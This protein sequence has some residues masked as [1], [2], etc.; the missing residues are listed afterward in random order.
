MKQLYKSIV[1]KLS[2]IDTIKHIDID[3]G[4]LDMPQKSNP[5]QYPALLVGLN[6]T[7][8]NRTTK[9]DRQ[10]A[11]VQI[12]IKCVNDYYL[13][14]AEYSSQKDKAHDKI[15]DL[16]ELVYLKLQNQ[17]GEGYSPL[18]R[19]SSSSV[20]LGEGTVVREV[21]FFCKYEDDSLLQTETTTPHDLNIDKEVI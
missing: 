20:F 18:K 14:S 7:Y 5:F 1:N 8:S 21:T 17:V 15:F 16:E 3:Y 2:A 9:G 6:A 13:N 19:V 11:D 12:T 4:Q 10:A